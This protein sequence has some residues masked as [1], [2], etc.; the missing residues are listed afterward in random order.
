MGANKSRLDAAYA[1]KETYLLEFKQEHW[2]IFRETLFTT[3]K[4]TEYIKLF[5]SVRR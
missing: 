5:S 1:Q 3:G 2:Q 4:R